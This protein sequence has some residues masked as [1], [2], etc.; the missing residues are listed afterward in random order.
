MR[1]RNYNEREKKSDKE[2]LIHSGNRVVTARPKGVAAKNTADSQPHS[3]YHPV[4]LEG[5]ERIGRARWIVTATGW[6]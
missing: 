5:F 4:S 2:A 1:N 3:L 6:K